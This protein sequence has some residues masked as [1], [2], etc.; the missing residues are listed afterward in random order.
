M[1]SYTSTGEIAARTSPPTTACPSGCKT[2]YA[3][4]AGTET[5]IGGGTEPAG[6]LASVTSPGGGVTNYAYDPV[7]DVMQ[8]TNP[9]GLITKYTY[10]NLGRELTQTQISDTYPAGLTTSYTYDS[11]DRPV[12]VTAPSVTDRVTGAVHTKLTT[13]SYDPDSD[14]L[15]AT[16]SDT[17]GGDPSR[18]TMNTYN[19]HG[20]LASVADPLG[21]TISYTYDALGDRAT[22]TDP[23]GQVTAFAYD[24]AGDLVSTTLEGYTGNPSNPIPAENLVQE[25]R[26][27][28]PAGRLASVTN[29]L[30]TTTYYTYYGNN[31]LASSY[32]EVSGSTV[33]QQVT[34]YG[35]DAA[36]NQVSENA[37]GALVI[38]SAYN[39]A[40]QPVFQTQDPSGADLITT[41]SYDPDGNVIAGTLAQ[42]GSTQTVTATYN[43]IGQQLSRTVQDGST[44]L[45]TGY[46][47]D[48]RGLITSVTDP[49]GTKT[50]IANDEAGRPVDIKAATEEGGE[51]EGD[52]EA[53]DAA[54][55]GEAD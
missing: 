9:L 39:A 3:Y 46:T 29:V 25:S 16:V 45:T 47:R 19:S 31:Q 6:L 41:A 33:E 5:A 32:V 30:G 12:T 23:D 1:T 8:V 20:Q 37:P 14:V 36:G 18:T 34:T 2:T 24:A 42:G 7:G 26:A 21:N 22:E 50:Q 13:Y 53:A 43:A 28:D 15:T 38:D 48:E 55:A 52:G 54:D 10:D 51:E 27:Y 35:Y 11:L 4:T 17:T 49:A 44:N 40:S